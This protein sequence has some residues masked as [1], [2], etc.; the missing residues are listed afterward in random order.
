MD[1]IVA[2]GL[3]AVNLVVFGHSRVAAQAAAPSRPAAQPSASAGTGGQARPGAAG[4]V[5]AEVRCAGA[6][7]R[8]GPRREAAR[9]RRSSSTGRRWRS[10]RRGTR[11]TGT[12]A[13]RSTRSS[14]SPRPATR[15]A[16]GRRAIRENGTAWALKGLCEFRLKNYDTALS[17]LVQARKRGVTGGRRRARRRPLP[18]PAILLTRAAQFDQALQILNDFGTQGNESPGVIEAMGLA[19][20]RMPHAARRTARHEAGA[21]ADGRAGPLLPGG[22]SDGRRAATRSSCSSPA[23]RIRRTSTTPTASSC[24]PSSPT[25]RSRSSSA[26]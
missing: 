11:G 23:I 1:R 6:R 12:S 24:W 18:Q 25:R 20:L 10:G 21:G 5:V 7:S 17:D 16:R 8:E 9:S 3:L 15:S 14:A 26:S 13:R 2:S 19:V 4:R 22:A